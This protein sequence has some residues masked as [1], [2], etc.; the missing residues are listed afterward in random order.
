M[1]IKPRVWRAQG[2]GHKTL[3]EVRP[4]VFYTNE[5]VYCPTI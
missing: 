2:E 1:S 5:I 3:Y 4:S